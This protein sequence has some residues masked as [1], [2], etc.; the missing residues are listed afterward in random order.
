MR[1][2]VWVRPR[3]GRSVV[4]GDRDGSL[5]V[6]VRAAPEGGKATEEALVALAAAFGVRRRQVSLVSGHTSRI[7]VVDVKGDDDDLKTRMAELRTGTPEQ[8]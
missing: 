6:R 5:I 2:T 3:S 7:K 8:D 4:G 1:V